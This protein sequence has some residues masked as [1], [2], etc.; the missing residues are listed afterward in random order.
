MSSQLP[1]P[2]LPAA[3]GI[4][5]DLAVKLA[6]VAEKSIR[7]RL[8]ESERNRRP[9][10]G[11]TLKPGRETPLWNELAAATR[12]QL[13]KRGEKA[14]LARLLGLPRQRIH[15]F[16]RERSALPDAERTL[17]LLLWLQA[18]REGRDLA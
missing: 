5:L 12:V 13:A 15:Q 14:K 10:R 2:Q 17:L 7:H 1:P 8:I 3:L 16:L 18:R 9:K 6:E 11:L 4:P